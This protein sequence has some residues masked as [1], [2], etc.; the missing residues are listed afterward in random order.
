MITTL[1]RYRRSPACWL[2]L[3]VFLLGTGQAR[4]QAWDQALT[5]GSALHNGYALANHSV[6]DAAGNTYLTG[7]FSGTVDFGGQLLSSPANDVFVAKI[8][9]GGAYLWAVRGGGV[10]NGLDA[11]AIGADAAGNVYI[12]GS[13]SATSATFGSIVLTTPT[14]YDNEGFVAKLSPSG[15][16]L[17]ATQIRGTG[18][19]AVRGVAVDA[20]AGTVYIAGGTSSG[21]ASLGTVTVPAY[22]A[23]VAQ[24]STAGQWQ[25]AQTSGGV[26]QAL[27]VDA[28]GNTY[29]AGT[30]YG[31]NA[32]F[33]S[34]TLTSSQQYITKAYVAKLSPTGQWLWA[35]GNSGDTNVADVALDGSGGIYLSGSIRYAATFG[36]ITL[37]T[38]T[39]QSAFVAKL[40]GS[41]QWTWAQCS[42]GSSTSEAAGHR[43]AADATGAVYLTGRLYGAASTFGATAIDPGPEFRTMGR[44]F[45]AKL[46][47][48]GQWL[49]AVRPPSTGGVGAAG[50]GLLGNTAVL[51]GTYWQAPVTF[52]STALANGS[53]YDVFVAQLSA[54]GQW[55]L[56]RGTSSG[57]RKQITAV[58]FDA[59]G[60]RY[61]AGWFN[62]RLTLGS[63]TLTSAGKDCFVAKL[64]A[65][66]QY[67]WAAQAG[68]SRLDQINALGLDAAGNAYVAGDF[69]S[70]DAQ[71]GSTTLSSAGGN[72]LDT[73]GF[74]AKLSAGGQWQ[75]AVRFG[76]AA[77]E[78]CPG[79][80]VDASGNASI[81]GGF[82]S[83]SVAFGSTTL[84]N[85]DGIYNPELYAAR[86]SPTGQWLWAVQGVGSARDVGYGVT[87]D[88]SGNTYVTG[89]F[90]SSSLALGTVGPL[91]GTGYSTFVAKLNGSGQWQ[92]GAHQASCT[93]S[94]LAFDGSGN[95]Y[96]AGTYYGTPNFGNGPLPS[97]DSA[98]VFVAKL[99]NGQWQWGLGAGAT[100]VERLNGLVV[101]AAGNAIVAGGYG[102]NRARFGSTTLYH[103]G[104]T[105]GFVAKATPAGQWSWAQPV[106]GAGATALTQHGGALYVA[107]NFTTPTATFGP[108]VLSNGPTTFTGSFLAKLL[109]TPLA[110]RGAEA[111]PGWATAYPSPGTE[112]LTVRLARAQSAPLELIARDALGRVRLQRTV[113]AGVGQTLTLPEAAAWP[114]GV[115]L[116]TVRQGAQQQVLKVVRQ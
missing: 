72:Y 58:A 59:A 20:A 52:G 81:T 32:S 107:G 12:A 54:A 105:Y 109:D 15:Q 21:P 99:S 112:P 71:F 3:F 22:T 96:V 7:T 70:P 16:W 114:A 2:L 91:T 49:W 42:G 8:S 66:G 115:Y 84:S 11:T 80:A 64:D 110:T 53:D 85:P 35:T 55:Q 18:A 14:A 102:S 34:Y 46:S 97:G 65:A 82:A 108:S 79:L 60:N 24:L 69:A 104:G 68:G 56:A 113:A 100:G 39:Y 94:N 10:G 5:V 106:P 37:P 88:A 19:V 61:V 98:N 4:A 78:L 67:L 50:I 87:L 33:G 29:V 47:S 111:V 116:L 17:W 48:A 57:V 25:W 75:W 30:Y 43:L 26:H 101:D 44:M 86:L 77:D 76:G 28:T 45:V 9:P 92:W 6:L 51:T 38:S 62:G 103:A 74:V 13:F 83:A 27:A 31:L 95:L 1:L 93:G 23:F 41:G 73:D 40:N 89:D 90:S 63:T 36:T